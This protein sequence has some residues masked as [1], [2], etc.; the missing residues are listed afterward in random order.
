MLSLRLPCALVAATLLGCAPPR[1]AGPLVLKPLEERRA[2][3]AALRA[4]EALGK[5]GEAGRSFELGDGFRL[6]E[7]LRISGSEY[8]VA[9]V[10]A[11]EGEG[12]GTK[13]PKFNPDSGALRL[14]HPSEDAVVLVLHAAAYRFDASGSDTAATAIA[15]EKAV[16]RDVADFVMHVVIPRKGL[17]TKRSASDEA[18]AP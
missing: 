11:E 7:E 1:T 5:R 6:R 4:I 14:L 10:T 17:A 13:L 9:Y 16:E 15:A 2:Q 8:G 12:A 3:A 18:S